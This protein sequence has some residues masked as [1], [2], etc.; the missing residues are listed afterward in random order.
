MNR[1]DNLSPFI[2]NI[3]KGV[4]LKMERIGW[5]NNQGAYFI[6]KLANEI[7]ELSDKQVSDKQSIIS[8]LS[9][10]ANAVYVD[11]NKELTARNFHEGILIIDGEMFSVWCPSTSAINVKHFSVVS[12]SSWTKNATRNISFGINDASATTFTITRNER[13]I[14]ITDNGN[15]SHSFLFMYL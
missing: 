14:T 7:E 4:N 1:G 11:W 6:N 8:Q 9:A 3:K 2:S 15:N 12:A 5:E 13:N 10:R